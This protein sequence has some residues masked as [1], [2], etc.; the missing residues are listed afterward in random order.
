MF[1]KLWQWIKQWWGRLLGR[2][3]Q[4]SPSEDASTSRTPRICTDS[5]CESLF[6]QLLEGVSQGWGRGRIQ[7]Y[8]IAK[9][10]EESQFV[11]WLQRFS[12]HLLENP[13]HHVELAQRLVRF[14]EETTTVSTMQALSALAGDIGRRILTQVPPPPPPSPDD[15]T[16][17]DEVIDAQFHQ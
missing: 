5:E 6:L 17:W 8:F 11:E 7:G 9:N 4:P 12:N 16:F 3:P 13:T 14:S 15:P 2:S 10:L 1:R